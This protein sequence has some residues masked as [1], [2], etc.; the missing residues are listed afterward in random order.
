[1][2]ATTKTQLIG[3]LT[4]SY[5]KLW[6]LLLA[7][8]AD[9]SGEKI[10]DGQIKNEQMSPHNLLSYLVGWCEEV[11]RWDEE[12]EKTGGIPTIPNSGYGEIAKK[13]YAQYSDVK[14]DDLVKKFDGV[15]GKIVK[16][17]QGK[18]DEELFDT[19]WY[20]AKSSGVEY[21][22]AKLIH[23]NTVAPWKNA[24]GRLMRY[25]TEVTK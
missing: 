20:T 15:N 22:F 4:N 18:T 24:R 3:N 7:I 21:N 19:P 13:L 8:P 23:L 14:Y 16:M 2:A 9:K 1:M 25:K 6:P 10:L 12:L 5:E 17:V 11:L